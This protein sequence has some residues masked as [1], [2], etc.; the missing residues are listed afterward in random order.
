MPT[1]CITHC[2]SALLDEFSNIDSI[3]KSYQPTIQSSVQLL[4]IESE[5]KNLSP[6][7]N[8]QSKRSLLPF[9]G[10]ALKWLTGTATT[11]DTW[12]IKQHLNQVIQE[13][14]QQQ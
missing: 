12:E 1:T 8:P 9:L 3:Y 6:S 13:W 7:E 11:K 4:K 14:T 5:F 10:D 2:L